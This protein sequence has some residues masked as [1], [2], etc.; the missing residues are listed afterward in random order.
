MRIISNF[1]DYYDSAMGFGQDP[2]LI[3]DR[4]ILKFEISDPEVLERSLKLFR[5]AKY[6]VEH[7]TAIVG[8]C[9][10]AYPFIGKE[11]LTEEDVKGTGPWSL[12]ESEFVE[13]ILL[14]DGVKPNTDAYRERAERKSLQYRD[15][16]IEPRACAFGEDI[17]LL[18]RSPVFVAIKKRTHLEVYSNPR[19]AVF[20]FAKIFHP[21][22]A[23]QEILMYLGSQLAVE[24][25]APSTVGDDKIIA[26]SKGFDEQSFRTAAPGTKKI[27]RKANRERKK[28]L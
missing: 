17:H 7:R 25:R 10:K 9:G 2:G 21:Y 19:L 23:F 12:S 13:H 16:C 22:E 11:V 14:T 27:N 26:Q 6:Y 1:H 28:G 3:Y 20:G 24:D 18:T 4:K 8:F 15:F 5:L